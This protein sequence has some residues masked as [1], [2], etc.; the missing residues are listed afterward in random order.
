[1]SSD[2]REYLGTRMGK[3][4]F[5]FGYWSILMKMLLGPSSHLSHEVGIV[6]YL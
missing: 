4:Q 2:E 3:K 5:D 1:M 6:I